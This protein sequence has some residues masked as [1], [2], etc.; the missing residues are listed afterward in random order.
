MRAPEEQ[1]DHIFAER[2]HRP[3]GFVMKRHHLHPYYEMYVV[4]KGTCRLFVNDAMYE[5]REGS[6]RIIPPGFLHYTRY[7]SD[8]VRTAVYFR[9]D[10]IHFSELSE[11][12]GFEQ[13]LSSLRLF[14]I[15]DGFRE[16][17]FHMLDRLI[18]ETQHPDERSQK[19]SELILQEFLLT[20]S[21]VSPDFS[22]IPARIAAGDETVLNAAAFIAAH[23]A[24]D[25]NLHDIAAITG[26]SDNY[27]SRRFHEATGTGVKEYL[28]FVRLRH[29]AQELRSTSHTITK[30]AGHCGFHDSKD[31]FKK[32]YGVSPREYRKQQAG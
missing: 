25:I 16:E 13:P 29:G 26:F 22:A 18:H 8:C 15:P 4:E 3:E 28:V 17:L 7:L 32:Q 5:L 20:S 2:Q 6:V 30:I 24:E 21:R 31:A 23:Y 10:M 19:I 11:L 12:P 27:F 9:E 1:I 14:H